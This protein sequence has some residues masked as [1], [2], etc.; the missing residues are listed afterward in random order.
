[1][2]R[3][4]LGNFDVT[5][6]DPRIIVF[7]NAIDDCKGLIEHYEKNAPWRGWFGFG[8]QVDEQGPYFKY[9]GD[10][11]DFPSYEE[12]KRVMIDT[13]PDMPIRQH[14]SERFYYATKEYVEYTGTTLPNWICKNWT[15]ARYIPDEN[16][17]NNE[18]LTMNYHT[19]Y[20]VGHH[21]LPGE[22][23]GIT[24]VIYPND[25]YEGG[26]IA[27]RISDENYQIAKEIEYKPVTGDIVI[28]PAEHPY[29]HGVRRIWNKAKYIIR[30][31][32][33]YERDATPEWTALKEKY[34]DKFKEMEQER[35]NRHDLMDADPFLRP[36]YS[37]TEYY[38]RLENGT[39]PDP[40]WKDGH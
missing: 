3:T 15:L 5:I 38:E 23:F 29:Y 12:W 36:M 30:A 24:A 4:K 31:Y 32:W 22:K 21:D 39:L 35:V 16:V 25:D 37:I 20:M 2:E 27:F 9:E 34:G 18:N 11:S 6:L 40:S 1:M 13:T 33:Q 28:F 8:R 7:H 14:V 19:D 26:E 17:I 10:N